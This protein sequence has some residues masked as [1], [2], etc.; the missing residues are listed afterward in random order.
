MGFTFPEDAGYPL[1]P[2]IGPL[3]YMMETHYNNPAQDSGI[4][5]SSGIRIYHTPILRRH[6]AGVLSVGLDPN[7]KH[8]IPPGQP[9]VVSEGHCISDC[10]KHAIPPAGVNIFAVNLHTHLIGK[11]NVFHGDFT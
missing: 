10:T 5:D 6:D 9:A 4:V 3:Y 1:D 2:H 7:W 11:K 8:I